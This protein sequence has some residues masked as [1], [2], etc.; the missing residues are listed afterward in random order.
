[1]SGKDSEFC[2]VFRNRPS[3]DR[4]AEFAQ[5]LFESR[6]GIG[7][8]GS[9]ATEDFRQNLF[10]LGIGD[11]GTGGAIRT[12]GGSKK[13]TQGNDS[14]RGADVFVRDGTADSGLVDSDFSRHLTHRQRVESGGALGKVVGLSERDDFEKFLQGF[15][16]A[17]ERLKKKAGRADSLFEVGAGLFIG[18]AI[19]QKIFIDVAN[20]EAG[21]KIA[22]DLGNPLVPIPDKGGLRPDDEVG[23][24]GS[25]GGTRT[26]RQAGNGIGS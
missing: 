5:H 10:C 24:I 1:M 20:P 4:N 2:T 13:E 22:F 18:S 7:F 23:T 8:V 15:L 6:I 16:A 9:F 14:V 17:L 25:E 3:G 12:Q 21:K 11:G 19:P 26:R